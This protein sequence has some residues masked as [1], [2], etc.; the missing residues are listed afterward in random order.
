M[1]PAVALVGGLSEIAA[2]AVSVAGELTHSLPLYFRTSSLAGVEMTT[3]ERSLSAP[4][5]V[6]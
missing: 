3:S 1:S 2:L 5:A 4:G 6:R